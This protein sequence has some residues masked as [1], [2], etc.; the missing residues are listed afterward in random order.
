MHQRYVDI[1]GTLRDTFFQDEGR[2]IQNCTQQPVLNLFRRERPGLDALVRAGLINDRG[3]CGRGLR[4][5][6]VVVVVASRRLAPKAPDLTQ[7]VGI[8]T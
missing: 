6:A 5:A 3:D 1:A 4:L 2:F 7:P 8:S